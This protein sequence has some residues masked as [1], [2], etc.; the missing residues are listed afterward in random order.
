[1]FIPSSRKQ[2]DFNL[3]HFFFFTCKLHLFW[4]KLHISYFLRKSRVQQE[5][6]GIVIMKLILLAVHT[7]WC[8]ETRKVLDCISLIKWSYLCS[9]TSI[10][11]CWLWKLTSLDSVIYMLNKS[12]TLT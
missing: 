4:P 7:Q 2:F 6:R 5:E 1:L 10:Y 8:H 12:I 9:I 11:R 3:G